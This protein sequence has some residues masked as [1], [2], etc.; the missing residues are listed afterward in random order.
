MP[1]E[2]LAPMVVIGIFGIALMLHLSGQ[3]RTDPLTAER[4]AEAWITQIPGVAS[5]Q[6][7]LSDDARVALVETDRGPGLLWVFGADCTARLFS[8]P[9]AVRET[10]DQIVVTTGDFT[11]PRIR[12]RLA[13]G[14]DRRR[15][16]DTLTQ[17]PV[18]PA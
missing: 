18:D 14:A 1:L 7:L 17:P 10:A 12:A 2:I 16:T 9:P 4:A 13:D 15:W 11:A 3:S 6:I 8:A 5:R